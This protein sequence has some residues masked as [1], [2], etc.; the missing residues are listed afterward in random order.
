MD[1]VLSE[2]TFHEVQKECLKYPEVETGGILVGRF[3][4]ED[5]QAIFAIGSGP[6]A[7]RS[8]TRFRPDVAWQQKQLDKYFEDY[9]LNYVGS[10]HRHFGNFSRPSIID[11]WAANQIL[12]DLDWEVR[13]AVFPIILVQGNAVEIYPY[14]IC[15]TSRKFER[16]SMKVVPDDDPSVSIAI[17]EEESKC[18][19]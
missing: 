9:G 18:A 4:S 2:R 13:K 19:E 17:K 3:K 8:V 14:Y 11:Y 7:H 16:I 6:A 1:L 5:V 12:S 10:F 15:R